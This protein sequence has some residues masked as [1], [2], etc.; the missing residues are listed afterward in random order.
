MILDEQKVSKLLDD[1]K[2]DKMEHEFKS[3]NN[4]IMPSKGNDNFGGEG[5]ALWGL[6]LGTL[7][8][9]GIVDRATGAVDYNAL[10]TQLTSIANSLGSSNDAILAAINA[11]GREICPAISSV[12]DAVYNS[13]ASELNAIGGVKD[14]VQTNASFTRDAITGLGA[15]TTRDTFAVLQ[16]INTNQNNNQTNFA[17]TNSNI[18]N[19]FAGVQSSLCHGF[20]DVTAG[21][22]DIKGVVRDTSYATDTNV[23]RNFADQNL[24]LLNNFNSARELATSHYNMLYNQAVVNQSATMEKLCEISCEQKAGF[25]ATDAK[26]EKSNDEQTIRAQQAY[27]HQL[28]HGNAKEESVR[29]HNEV[30]NNSKNIGS[31]VDSLKGLSYDVRGMNDRVN[32]FIGNKTNIGRDNEIKS[33]L[34]DPRCP[35]YNFTVTA[36]CEIDNVELLPPI[37]GA[38]QKI[39]VTGSGW[40]KVKCEEVEAIEES[41]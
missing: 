19:G 11:N 13:S 38:E 36:G 21:Q 37:G 30:N 23:N 32:F 6:L 26:I 25:V 15:Q 34:H 9:R 39:K 20:A 17:T 22:C 24:G 31:I 2:E 7:Y 27:I 40:A 33:W 28:E 1:N 5:G 12:K 41:V 18:S 16:G 10:T 29:I 35:D 4:Y 14:S 8:N 3:N